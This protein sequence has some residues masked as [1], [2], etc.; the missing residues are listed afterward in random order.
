MDACALLA[1][2]RREAGWEEAYRIVRY[3]ECCGHIA[4]M[5]EVFYG[6][7]SEHGEAV[8][9]SALED[10]REMGIVTYTDSD[11]E[12]WGQVGLHKLKLG[13]ISLADCMCLALARRLGGEIVTTDHHEFDQVADLGLCRVR[14]IR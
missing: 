1:I 4:N 6:F 5:C 7:G 2:L 11:P 12:F 10:F 9:H 8:G 13:R 3:E 14:F